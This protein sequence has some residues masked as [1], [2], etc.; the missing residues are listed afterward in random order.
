[1][2]AELVLGVDF[3]ITAAEAKQKKLEEGWNQAKRKVEIQKTTIQEI[4]KEI[5]K[6]SLKSE[7][8]ESQLDKVDVKLDHIE[9][10]YAEISKMS[11]YEQATKGTGLLEEKEAL[12]AKQKELIA[13]IAKSEQEEQKYND[14]LK[15][16][17]FNLADLESKQRKAG[18][19]LALNN[20]KIQE[21]NAK[22]EKN[23]NEQKNSLKKIHEQYQKIDDKLVE[24]G[25]HIK[26]N[27]E[28]QKNT[29]NQL[30]SNQNI[31]GQEKSLNEQKNHSKG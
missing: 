24:I 4:Q 7:N 10:K 9:K 12:V 30:A 14:K 21:D 26:E 2:A 18:L 11:A 28:E 16:A 5:E 22:R 1:M 3:D 20:A 6:A 15:I 25:Q 19:D 17:K 23:E 8:Y 29:L 27:N 31:L 13:L